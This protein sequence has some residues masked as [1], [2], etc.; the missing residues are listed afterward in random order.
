VLPE[1]GVRGAAEVLHRG[2]QGCE[3]AD[4]REHGVAQ[5]F[6]E[7]FAA[8]ARICRRSRRY[9]AVTAASPGSDLAPASTSP[10]S[11]VLI[12]YT[13]AAQVSATQSI[14][15]RNS[16]SGTAN[17]NSAPQD[18]SDGPARRTATAQDAARCYE[19]ARYLILAAQRLQP[20]NRPTSTV[21]GSMTTAVV[22]SRSPVSRFGSATSSPGPP[23]TRF[24][25]NPGLVIHDRDQPSKIAMMP[26][27]PSRNRGWEVAPARRRARP[28]E[29]VKSFRLP[30]GPY[31]HFV[32]CPGGP[33]ATASTANRPGL[34]AA[35][36]DAARA[37]LVT[38]PLKTSRF[39]TQN[40][41]TNLAARLRQLAAV[42]YCSNAKF[43]S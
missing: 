30:T 18:V 26:P 36:T 28:A 12:A 24:A 42:N 13:H 3:H 27:F 20:G 23:V 37:I 10:S 9:S 11:Q 33:S 1:V 14:P 22:N 8:G 25:L 40:V 4:R 15:V 43:T 5:C 29:L 35:R 16:A 32:R 6:G 2:V 17:D 38:P 41:R 19:L 7:R 31:E 34:R 39:P 21:P